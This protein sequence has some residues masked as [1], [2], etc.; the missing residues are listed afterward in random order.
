MDRPTL[1]ALH[2]RM[3]AK[4]L[5]LLREKNKDYGRNQ[6]FGN[7]DLVDFLTQGDVSTEMGILIRAAD[8]MARMFNLLFSGKQAVKDESFED[9]ILDLFNYGVLLTAKKMQRKEKPHVLP[10]RRSGHAEDRHRGGGSP[11]KLRRRVGR[12]RP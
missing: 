5:K 9:A 8:K 12:P 2:K 4:A 11:R 10:R 6:V 3:S 1:F 7:L